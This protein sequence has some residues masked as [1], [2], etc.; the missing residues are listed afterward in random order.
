[1]CD[2]GRAL[3]QPS[4]DGLARVTVGR[5]IYRTVWNTTPSSPSR[6]S[7]FI[8][9]EWKETERRTFQR[10]HLE[11]RV[12]DFGFG[13]LALALERKDIRCPPVTRVR[14]PG[15]PL[16]GERWAG[17]CHLTSCSHPAGTT[18]F[19]WME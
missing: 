12:A 7:N 2:R 16:W 13:S 18:Q 8:G 10:A 14:S 17:A 6:H 19:A 9:G 3:D 4:G 15:L 1:M 11:T 5:V